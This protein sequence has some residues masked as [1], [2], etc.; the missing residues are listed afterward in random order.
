MRMGSYEMKKAVLAT[1]QDNI[2]IHRVLV[3]NAI[4]VAERDN[5]ELKHIYITIMGQCSFHRFPREQPMAYIIMFEEL[6]LFILNG[7]SE[8]H[9]LCKLFPY[10]LPGNEV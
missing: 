3:T 1:M 10:S 5:F 6:V 4:T 8:G 2:F 9:H 7:V